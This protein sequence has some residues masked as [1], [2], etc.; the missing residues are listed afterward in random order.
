MLANGE[1]PCL[2]GRDKF[3]SKSEIGNQDVTL[4]SFEPPDYKRIDLEGR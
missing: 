2:F 3:Q 4:F 1:A